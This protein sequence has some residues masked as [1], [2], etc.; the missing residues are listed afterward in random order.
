VGPMPCD[1][2]Y[3]DLALLCCEWIV[4][5]EMRAEWRGLSDQVVVVA[6]AFAISNWIVCWWRVDSHSNTEL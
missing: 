6:E 2:N 3:V 1:G 5:G 4:N